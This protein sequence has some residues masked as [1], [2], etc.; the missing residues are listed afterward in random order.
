M[1]GKLLRRIVIWPIPPAYSA[2]AVAT[3]VLAAIIVAFAQVRS[4]PGVLAALLTG[5]VAV[6][7]IWS[8]KRRRA[9]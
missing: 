7:A 2:Q 6:C 8:L 9:D 1:M 4:F 3:V 5:F